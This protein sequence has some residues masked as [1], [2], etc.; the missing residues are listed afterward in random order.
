MVNQ[1]INH[2]VSLV[3]QS[4]SWFISKMRVSDSEVLTKYITSSRYPWAK[5]KWRTSPTALKSEQKGRPRPQQRP[6]LS[7]PSKDMY[8]RQVKVQSLCT[9]VK[10]QTQKKDTQSRSKSTCTCLEKSVLEV[11]SLT[12]QK[13]LH[14]LDC[15]CNTS[16]Y[17][18]GVYIYYWY[19]TLSATRCHDM[20]PTSI[21]NC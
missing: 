21:N 13:V 6:S 10:V 4:P 7:V 8:M 9:W 18:P 12:D 19:K 15:K 2:H 17:K 5:W 11:Q 1:S 3:N 14:W 16:L 20:Q